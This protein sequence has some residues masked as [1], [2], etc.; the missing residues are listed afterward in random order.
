[1]KKFFVVLLIVTFV[2]LLI[3]LFQPT[4]AQEIK[5][6]DKATVPAWEWVEVRNL[7]PVKG[8]NHDFGFGDSCGIEEGGTVTV[9]GIEGGRLLVHYSISG[10]KFGTPCPNGVLFFTTKERFSRMTAEYNRMRAA[11]QGEKDTV[12]R[13]L[14]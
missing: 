14:K 13:L 6:G 8:G 3:A 7:E 1:M 5:K 9:V 2:G 4:A 10:T 12:R 11:K